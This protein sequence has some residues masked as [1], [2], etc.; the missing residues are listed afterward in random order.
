[1]HAFNQVDNLHHAAVRHTFIG[2]NQH[3]ALGVFFLLPLQVDLQLIQIATFAVYLETAI[4]KN[5]HREIPIGGCD[6]RSRS[7]RQLDL[8]PGAFRKAGGQHKEEKQIK[9]DIHQRRHIDVWELSS[10]AAP[11]GKLHC[12]ET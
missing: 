6:L 11:S 1:M 8:E 3:H 7:F 2:L 5:I 4:W 12:N 10:L 9:D